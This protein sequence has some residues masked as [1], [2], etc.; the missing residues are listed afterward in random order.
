[1]VGLAAMRGA[2]Q[3]QLGLAHPE[4][5]GGA[6]LDQGQRLERLDG[7]AWIDRLV[8][9][10]QGQ[11]DSAVGVGDAQAD[12]MPA[13]HPLAPPHLDRNRCRRHLLPSRRGA[14]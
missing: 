12:A 2:G 9:V 7:R 1:M 13:L 14:G 8:D 10:A 11:E 4:A 5:V 3:R 6:A